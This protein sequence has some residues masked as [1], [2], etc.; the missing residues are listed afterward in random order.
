MQDSITTLYSYITGGVT[1]DSLKAWDTF[2]GEIDPE[3]NW[4]P[5][6]ISCVPEYTLEFEGTTINVPVVVIS[7]KRKN[8]KIMFLT[9]GFLWGYAGEGPA[10]LAKLLKRMFDAFNFEF[11][12]LQN[13]KV[14]LE[15]EL[16][17][18]ISK[19]PMDLGWSANLICLAKTCCGLPD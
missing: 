15:Y 8:D 11:G 10:G 14:N 17:Q 3:E 1:R 2:Y 9:D 18:Y 7:F 12:T 6:T 16:L 5:E 4:E 19:R 13:P